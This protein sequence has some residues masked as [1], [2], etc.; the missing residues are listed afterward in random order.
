MDSYSLSFKKLFINPCY[1]SRMFK[2]EK[3][4]SIKQY[5]TEKRISR[6]K[7]MLETENIPINVIASSVGIYDSL[8]FSRLFKK[9][10]GFS[11]KKYVHEKKKSNLSSQPT[12]KYPII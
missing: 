11:P 12:E 8:Y 2:E 9:Y 1:L 4:I 6:A 7:Q 3:N 10:T 5:L